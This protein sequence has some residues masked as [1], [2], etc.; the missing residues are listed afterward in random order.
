MSRHYALL[1]ALA[2]PWQVSKLVDLKT[3]LEDKANNPKGL[4]FKSHAERRRHVKDKMQLKIVKHPTTGAECVPVHDKTLMLSGHRRSAKR[5]KQQEHDSK[6]D[7]KE[8]CD[9]AASALKVSTNSRV[10]WL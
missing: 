7:L 10:A 6:E 5:E 9:K 2:W 1:Q 4:V 3:F 8:D